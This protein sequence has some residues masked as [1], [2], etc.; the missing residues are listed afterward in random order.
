M[1][2]FDAIWKF[3]IESG[4]QYRSD[5]HGMAH[6]KRVERNALYLAED[7]D[8]DIEVIKLFAVFHD[9]KR[10]SDGFDIKHG[11]RAAEYV[12]ELNGTIFKLEG[13]RCELLCQACKKH[14]TQQSTADLVMGI[15]WDADRLDIGRIG[16]EP[17]AKFFNTEKAKDIVEKK[18]YA[19]LD[20][21]PLRRTI[22][23]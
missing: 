8:A 15:C 20:D 4:D 19:I 18:N 10:E 13:D 16:I 23:E 22:E 9:S 7:T 5:I 11:I 1:I 12:N 17:D 6:W 2:N 21:R 14:T 3:V